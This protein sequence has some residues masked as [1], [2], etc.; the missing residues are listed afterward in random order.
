MATVNQRCRW[1]GADVLAVVQA[2]FNLLADVEITLE[3]NPGAVGL[4]GLTRLRKIG[5]K[6]A[7]K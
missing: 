6:P 5:V 4:D 1:V 2:H 7:P 3:T